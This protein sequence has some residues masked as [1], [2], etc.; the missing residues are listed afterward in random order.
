MAFRAARQVKSDEAVGPGR[1]RRNHPANNA[2]ALKETTTAWGAD[3]VIHDVIQ[4]VETDPASSFARPIAKPL[5]TEIVFIR[6][7]WFERNAARPFDPVGEVS[8]LRRQ[9]AL[10]R[11]ARRF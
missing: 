3:C 9:W 11:W 2:C 6:K 8:P 1:K 4:T 5:H 10:W 7:R